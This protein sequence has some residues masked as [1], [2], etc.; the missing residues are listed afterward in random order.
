MHKASLN[1]Y[2]LYLHI[3]VPKTATTALQASLASRQKQLLEDAK[4]LY[5]TSAQ[6][7]DSSHH[8][9]PFKIANNKSWSSNIEEIDVFGRLSSEI[10]SSMPHCIILSSELIVGMEPHFVIDHLK[11]RLGPSL[12]GITIL[13][14]TRS[15]CGY[16]FSIYLQ[17][18]KDPV[19]GCTDT[20][21]DFCG[22]RTPFY[23]IDNFNMWYKYCSESTE[24]S[25]VVEHYETRK[26]DCPPFLNYFQEISNL[27]PA[28]ASKR[29]NE[30]TS[31][32]MTA[33]SLYCYRKYGSSIL[34][35]QKCN[36]WIKQIIKENRFNIA[37][38]SEGLEIVFSTKYVEK[39]VN[40]DFYSEVE[41]ASRNILP[42]RLAQNFFPERNEEQL[43]DLD[44]Y[45]QKCGEEFGDDIDQII[46]KYAN[47]K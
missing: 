24:C 37:E 43:P 13:C 27:R 44:V 26:S 30:R 40:S 4:I 29:K 14:A 33:L 21:E 25:M 15:L 36:Y 1:D 47:L 22:Q 35:R 46:S 6:W 38:R 10:Q 19:M 18:I 31:Y 23:M 7:V 41:R 20:F 8:L 3:G 28:L 34:N 45:Y 11:D 42:S 32:L 39:L 5:P 17:N 9:I 12:S 2:H 16:A